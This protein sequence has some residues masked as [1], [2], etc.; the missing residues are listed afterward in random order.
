MKE[1]HLKIKVEKGKR[2]EIKASE[3]ITINYSLRIYNL[4]CK[5]QSLLYT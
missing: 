3:V 4:T 2:L 1:Y 5:K